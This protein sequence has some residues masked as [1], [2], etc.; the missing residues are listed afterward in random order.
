MAVAHC[1]KNMIRKH[2]IKFISI[3][4]SIY[5]DFAE[6]C[7]KHNIDYFAIAGT[8]IGQRSVIRALFP[9]MTIL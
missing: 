7:N 4:L 2:L 6:L 5:K 1:L 9:G 8:S 3:N